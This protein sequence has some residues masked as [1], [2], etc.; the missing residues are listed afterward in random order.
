MISELGIKEK[1]DPSG[2]L[3]AETSIKEVAPAWLMRLWEKNLSS[4][5]R[6]AHAER[7]QYSKD[8]LRNVRR[9]AQEWL[10]GKP[11]PVP[12]DLVLAVLGI[13]ESAFQSALKKIQEEEDCA[14]KEKSR[15]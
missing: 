3:P 4:A 15:A 10:A 9:K 6:D 13:S 12:V 2:P 5:L 1:I 8:S 14:N 7:T 11:A